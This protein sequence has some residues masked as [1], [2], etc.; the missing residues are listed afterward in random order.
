MPPNGDD[1]GL[2]CP[3]GR[4]PASRTIT[5]CEQDPVCLPGPD[6]RDNEYSRSVGRSEGHVDRRSTVDR[7]PSQTTQESAPVRCLS[8]QPRSGS[9]DAWHRPEGSSAGQSRECNAAD[10]AVPSR[11]RSPPGLFCC[12]RSMTSGAD[13][14]LPPLPQNPSLSREAPHTGFPDAPPR[15]SV[16]WQLLAD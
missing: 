6:L 3:P 8:L 1:Q 13:A 12:C 14:C 4:H 10:H 16:C 11:S 9:C 2:A 7:G 15:P 5:S